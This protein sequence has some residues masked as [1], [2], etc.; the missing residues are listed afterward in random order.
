MI[1]ELRNISDSWWTTDPWSL[2]NPGAK[3]ALSNPE[4]AATN[5]VPKRDPT[6]LD[7]PCGET[8][9]RIRL[10]ARPADDGRRQRLLQAEACVCEHLK[11][12]FGND[13]AQE[14]SPRVP[15]R[16]VRSAHADSLGAR[17]ANLG[18]HRRLCWQRRGDTCTEEEDNVR[19]DLHNAEGTECTPRQRLSCTSNGRGR[20]HKR[21]GGTASARSTPT[22]LRKPPAGGPT[23]SLCRAAWRKALC[24]VRLSSR[25]LAWCCG[26]G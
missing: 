16:P 14:G 7:D 1:C 6:R 23:R 26:L 25:L 24:R 13:M 4:T 3:G 2:P 12:H 20:G 11:E 9:T 18:K 8:M 15:F 19:T 10:R 5:E 17:V 21:A 22:G